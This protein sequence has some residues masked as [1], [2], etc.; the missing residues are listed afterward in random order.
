MAIML[1]LPAVKQRVGM[2]TSQIY[3]EM[4]EGRFPPSAAL[5]EG[6]RAQGWFDDEIDAHV[7]TR[8]KARDEKLA[9]RRKARD[10]KQLAERAQAEAAQA[11]RVQAETAR[12]TDQRKRLRASEAKAPAAVE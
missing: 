6:A 4:A 3:A 10:E 7:E 8:R 2:S 1:R 9:E 5:F 12:G 11:E